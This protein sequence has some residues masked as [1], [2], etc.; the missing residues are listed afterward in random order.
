MIFSR[1]KLHSTYTYWKICCCCWTPVLKS[2]QIISSSG[3]LLFIIAT[4]QWYKME[5]KIRDVRI[6]MKKGWL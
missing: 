5:K 2:S 4:Y 6:Q 1:V 3:F